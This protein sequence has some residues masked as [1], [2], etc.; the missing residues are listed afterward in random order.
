MSSLCS[1]KYSIFYLKVTWLKVPL[2]MYYMLQCLSSCCGTVQ[3]S[4][5]SFVTQDSAKIQTEH[6]K[7]PLPMY[8]P[9][10]LY[11]LKLVF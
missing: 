4:R 11:Y 9:G 10:C 7:I 6:L 3:K 5:I 2:F 1:F 8:L